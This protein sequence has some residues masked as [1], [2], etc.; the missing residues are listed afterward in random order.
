MNYSSLGYLTG[1]NY[2]GNMGWFSVPA[3]GEVTGKHGAGVGDGWGQMGT[4]VPLL[5]P[6]PSQ[7]SA[8]PNESLSHPVDLQQAS[9]NKSQSSTSSRHLKS[10]PAASRVTPSRGAAG[11]HDGIK[12]RS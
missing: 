6:A 12:E 11:T 1:K 8:P 4:D 3:W 9:G 5:H 10:L 7:G 2:L